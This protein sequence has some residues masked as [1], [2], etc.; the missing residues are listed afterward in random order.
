MHYH[1]N[2]PC[3]KDAFIPG[4]PAYF[5]TG[6]GPE[7]NPAA[8]LPQTSEPLSIAGALAEIRAAADPSCLEGTTYFHFC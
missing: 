4:S 8:L 3:P 5:P 2:V 1:K 7:I 6:W